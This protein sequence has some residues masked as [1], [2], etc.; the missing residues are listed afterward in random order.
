MRPPRL[1][2]FVLLVGAVVLLAG[3]P[4]AR[5]IAVPTAPPASAPSVVLVTLDTTRADRMGFLGS[6]RGL[7]PRLDA[8]AREA[9]VFERAYAQAPITTVSHA[10]L[11]SGT[12]PQLHG[13]N[14]FG[15]PLPPSVPWLPELLQARGYRTAAFVGSL[16]LD[17]RGGLAPGFDRGFDSYEAG[18][19]VRR[20][21]E[22]R[23]QTM[24]RRAGDVMGRALKWLD[25]RKGEP[26]MVWVHLYDAHDPYEA[27][28]PFG[29]RHAKAPYDGEVAYVD[30]QVGRLV[31]ALRARSLYDDTVVVVAADHGESLGEHGET[32]HGV[33]LYDSTIRVPLLLKLAHGR[34]A[35]RRA[36][37]RAGLVDVAPTVLD[38]VGAPAPA[39]MQGESLL[40]FVEAPR[41][42]DRPAYA[43]TDYPRRAFGW[44]PLASWRADRFLF[45][46]APRPELY[47][48][49]ADPSAARNVADERAAVAGRI[50]EEMQA[51]RG[52]T[53]AGG[54]TAAGRPIDPALAE[55]LAALGYVGAASVSPAAAGGIDPKDKIGVAN[56]LHDAILAVEGGQ[57]DRAVLLLDKVVATDPQIH[58]AQFQLGVA[59]A[60]QRRYPEAIIH[61]KK[62]IE[63]QPDALMAH[64]EMGVALF[65]TGDLKT[66]AGHFEI[67]A[68]RMPKW[69][70]ARYSYGSVL[71]RISRVPEAVAEL[72]AALDLAPGHYRAN[73]LLGRILTLQGQPQAG[74]PHLEKAVEAQ[75]GSREARLFLADAY[76]A[77]GR[78]ADADRER[79]RAGP[80]PRPSEN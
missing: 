51:F 44:S 5:A 53:S 52:R 22:D 34:L 73:L 23:Y 57:L 66:A 15:V 45:V 31:E 28:A 67:V 74:V 41:P 76:R 13:V 63:L 48:V 19:R 25:E 16:I 37:V 35:G 11:L 4:R 79:A 72:R 8:L 33:F 12:Y 30:A 2:S 36:T 3:A 32:T 70:D 69:A 62:A 20:G 49:T 38:A 7:T 10:T 77:L 24:E 29:P 60:R 75:P 26:F 80:P 18:F 50:A 59:R 9:V 39:P 61:L 6:G 47:D 17:P 55:K 43:E 54:T 14:D 64:Y 58:V 56:V 65:E 71:A 40:P 27:P 78:D 42:P 21:K 46:R 68:S 1:L